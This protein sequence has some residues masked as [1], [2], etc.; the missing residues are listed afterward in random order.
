MGQPGRRQGQA[1]EDVVGQAWEDSFPHDR[2]FAHIDV[3]VELDGRDPS[4]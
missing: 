2:E 1:V 3:D 4:Q